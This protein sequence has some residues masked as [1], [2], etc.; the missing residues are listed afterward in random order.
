MDKGEKVELVRTF[1]GQRGGVN[2]LRFCADI[3][4]GRLL[5]VNPNL[6]G[7]TCLNFTAFVTD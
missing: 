1:F 4:Y 7:S 2:F 5:T 6:L 3:F